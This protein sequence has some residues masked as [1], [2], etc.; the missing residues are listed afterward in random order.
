VVIDIVR[1]SKINGKD[2][3]GTFCFV[4]A[5]KTLHHTTFRDQDSQWNTIVELF[6]KT[7]KLGVSGL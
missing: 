2:F 4:K 3:M 1:D 7:L 5:T 6:W